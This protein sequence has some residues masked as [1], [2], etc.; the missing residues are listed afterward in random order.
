MTHRPPD[1]RFDTTPASISL[2]TRRR[3]FAEH[4]AK[5][6]AEVAVD[7]GGVQPE[8]TFSSKLPGDER[9]LRGIPAIG[10]GVAGAIPR[11][12]PGDGLYDKE[13]DDE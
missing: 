11:T 5:K 9:A 6:L 10:R 1:D 2:A 4:C 3:Q 12:R 8:R 7:T 13:D